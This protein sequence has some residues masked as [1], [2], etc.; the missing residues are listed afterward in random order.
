MESVKHTGAKNIQSVYFG[1][2]LIKQIGNNIDT[3]SFKGEA[4]GNLFLQDYIVLLVAVSIR[5]IAV[6]ISRSKY[7]Y[8]IITG[9]LKG[10]HGNLD[11]GNLLVNDLGGISLQLNLILIVETRIVQ[12]NP[13][14][15]FNEIATL[16]IGDL[17][18]IVGGN[19]LTIFNIIVDAIL[20]YIKNDFQSSAGI[21]NFI[22]A[23]SNARGSGSANSNSHS[24][25]A[26]H[27]DSQYQCEYFF[28][29]DFLL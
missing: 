26:N 13:A 2:V 20:R 25:G 22:V 11:V 12:G 7:L 3:I 18:Y 8:E 10:N 5:N 23:A 24:H 9:R 16:S 1:T 6:G 27:D 15:R 14:F 19:E 17:Y 28:H 4:V 21:N 29:C